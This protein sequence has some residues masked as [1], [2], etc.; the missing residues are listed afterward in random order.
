V[1]PFKSGAVDIG[2]QAVIEA[3]RTRPDWT[4]YLVPLALKYRYRE[5][6]API[7]ERR[8]R[9]MERHLN[10]RLTGLSLQQRLAQ[11]MA[12]LL[13]R[14]ELAHH[15][16]PVADRLTA[17]GER[18]QEVR[19]AILSQAEARYAGAAFNSQAPTMDRAWRLS[20]YLRNLLARR[21]SADGEDREQARI[22]LS[23]SEGVAQ[24]G[25]WQPRYTDED[26]SPERL[27]EMVIKLEREIYRTKRPRQLAPRELSL[28]IGEPID[29][30]RFT[31]DYLR[32]AQELRRSL[33]E[34]LRDKIQGL[35]ELVAPPGETG[36]TFQSMNEAPDVSPL[37]DTR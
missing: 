37:T 10:R 19:K 32:D 1:Q 28:R 8:T 4:A 3:R 36:R 18:V 26:A 15:L 20:S 30:S 12:D 35:L 17:L 21:G 27:A 6:I 33:A 23:S 5:P 11:I 2:M 16:K 22:D 29:V 14:Q 25:G 34:Q 7:L 9:S 31:A 24:M 13:R